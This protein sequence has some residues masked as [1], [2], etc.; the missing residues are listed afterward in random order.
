MMSTAENKSVVLSFFDS[1][2]AGKLD[3][4]LGL[5]A[6]TVT[7]WVAGQPEQFALAGT[8]DKARYADLVAVIGTAMPH[9][10]RVTITGLTAEKDR[11]AV[12][13][14]VR[15]ESAAGKIYDNRLHYLFEVREGKI[16]AAREY[17]DTIHAREVLADQ[18]PVPVP[19]HGAAQ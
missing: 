18:Q 10:I 12:E 15:G 3:A 6:D 7:W 19:A 14:E 5:M 17:L 13:A 8:Y 11:V 2:S 16:Q 9:G 4:A 1:L